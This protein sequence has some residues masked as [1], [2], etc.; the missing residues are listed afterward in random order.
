MDKD[1]IVFRLKI[2]LGATAF[3][4]CAVMALIAVIT[5]GVAVLNGIFNEQWSKS[6]YG[7]IGFFCA[8]FVL[9]FQLI[10]MLE[11]NTKEKQE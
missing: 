2:A 9:I 4:C 1:M 8:V 3:I 7:L 6:L 5:C 11:H 10:L